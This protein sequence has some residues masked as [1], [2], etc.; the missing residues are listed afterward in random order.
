MQINFKALVLLSFK[1]KFWSAVA[2]LKVEFLMYMLMDD[3][4]NT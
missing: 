2:T 4:L 3:E 1:E